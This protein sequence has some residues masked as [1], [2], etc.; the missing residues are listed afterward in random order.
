MKTPNEIAQEAYDQ[1]DRYLRNNLDDDG[2]AELS[3]ALDAVYAPPPN[4]QP[5]NI[6]DKR[7]II[8]R[9]YGTSA[10]AQEMQLCDAI[11]AAINCTTP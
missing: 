5:L 4:R 3:L 2:Y 6:A 9:V 8:R 7:A 1:I 10:T 11:E